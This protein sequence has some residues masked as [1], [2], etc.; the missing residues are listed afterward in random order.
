MAKR[1]KNPIGQKPFTGDLAEPIKSRRLS[2]L[3]LPMSA[4]ERKAWI[5]AQDLEAFRE[6]LRK[7]PLLMQHYGID[8][9]DPKAGLS[10]AFA[11]ATEFV[12][13]F[14]QDITAP[15]PRN[16]PKQYDNARLF[17]LLLRVE[18]EKWKE[19]DLSDKAA[20]ERVAVKDNPRLKSPAFESQRVARTKTMINVLAKARKV[21]IGDG[22]PIS[23]IVADL[24]RHVRVIH[25]GK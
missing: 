10:L 4:A 17:T 19:P 6:R 3:D 5:E 21:T 16:R 2:M 18:A 9:A 13:G 24:V 15:R 7:L 20:C 11:L 8:K 25:P 14:E 12:P 22:I 23:E 1:R